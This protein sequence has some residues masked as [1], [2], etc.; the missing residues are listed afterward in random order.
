MLTSVSYTHLDVY[1]RQI[2]RVKNQKRL[3]DK[4]N[5]T[6]K[7]TITTPA[8]FHFKLQQFT[9][10]SFRIGCATGDYATNVTL[11]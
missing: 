7:A 1:K 10:F 4:G 2:L 6:V 8:H 3:K 5:E 11:C 9:C